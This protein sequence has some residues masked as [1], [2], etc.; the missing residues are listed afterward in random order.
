MS[1][2]KYERRW[3]RNQITIYYYRYCT[4]QSLNNAHART[5]A[6]HSRF[7]RLGGTYAFMY[8]RVCG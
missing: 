8:V 3:W 1:I 7:H 6:S 5:A 2:F 4:L